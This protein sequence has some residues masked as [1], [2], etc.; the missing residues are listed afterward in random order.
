M[1]KKAKAKHVQPSLFDESQVA[2]GQGQQETVEF[3]SLE[4]G[5]VVLIDGDKSRY[6]VVERVI[7]DHV[8]VWNDTDSDVIE[9]VRVARVG[10]MP[11]LVSGYANR[12]LRT[13]IETFGYWAVVENL[14]SRQPK[15]ARR[16]DQLHILG[17][18]YSNSTARYSDTWQLYD[19]D[20]E[21]VEPLVDS[22]IETCRD[23]EI[24]VDQAVAALFDR[25]FGAREK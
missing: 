16:K 17:V 23:N 18:Q 19:S 13:L 12:W 21:A 11:G 4:P 24:P 22:F 1:P 7:Y 14:G 6:W 15:T 20:L 25:Y 9:R 3:E 5:D 2:D 8:A 10:K